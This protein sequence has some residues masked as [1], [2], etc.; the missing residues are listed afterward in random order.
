L[1]KTSIFRRYSQ[2]EREGS[3]M[4]ALGSGVVYAIVQP[5]AGEGDT[6]LHRFLAFKDESQP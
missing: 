6:R 1:S 4:S 5:E 3:G 2:V